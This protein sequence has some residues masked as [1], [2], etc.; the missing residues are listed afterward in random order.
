VNLHSSKLEKEVK[1]LLRQELLQSPELKEEAKKFKKK[2]GL[3]VQILA[4]SLLP[5][6]ILAALVLGVSQSGG[7]SA[8]LF[9]ITLWASIS[10]CWM[11]VILSN[12]LYRASDLNVLANL[13]ISDSNIFKWECGKYFRR[14]KLS[15]LHY[16][17]AFG[18]IAFHENV[19]WSGGV[20]ML[21]I[22]LLQWAL[23]LVTGVLMMA[24]FPRFPYGWI[25]AGS[26]FGSLILGFGH[27]YFWPIFLQFVQ[28]A[29]T[30]P[31]WIIPTGWPSFIVKEALVGNLL[32]GLMILIPMVALAFGLKDAFIRLQK[33]YIISEDIGVAAEDHQ[34]AINDGEHIETQLLPAGRIGPTE[35][36][37]NI[38]S[39]K[40]LKLLN[41]ESLPTI[42][43]LAGRFFNSREKILSEFMLHQNLNWTALWRKGAMIT[44]ALIAVAP[45]HTLLNPYFFYIPF[46]MFWFSAAVMVLP[47]FNP[48]GSVFTPL[49]VSGTN[50]PFY[51]GFPISYSE[52]SKLSFK[53]TFVRWLAAIPL[54]FLLG[55]T[56]C[57]IFQISFSMGFVLICKVLWLVVAAQP[58]LVL[59]RFSSASNDTQMPGFRSKLIALAIVFAAILFLGTA[60]TMFFVH[61]LWPSSMFCVLPAVISIGSHQL[62]GRIFVRMRFDLLQVPQQQNVFS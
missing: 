6:I 50:I 48:L 19:S 16:I 20:G 46:L 53:I 38:R 3:T 35:I 17:L 49:F 26:I 4:L 37:D 28:K 43:K 30:L 52:I 22:A 54:S 15:T 1:R 27:S 25:T 23:V 34:V 5:A 29:S 47:I 62:Y 21:F 51:A 9:A 61:S 24:Y 55:F 10:V 8:Q 45:L 11:V 32:L 13:P 41:W 14:S 56:L 7:V 18:L 40:S 57:W 44:L 59:C 31:Y 39:R 58:F 12:N 33:P 36:E 60:A 2:K 42:Q